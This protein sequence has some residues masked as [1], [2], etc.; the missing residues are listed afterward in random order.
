VVTIIPGNQPATNNTAARADPTHASP[1][2]SGPADLGK[3]VQVG[4]GVEIGKPVTVGSPVTIATPVP[5]GTAT[6]SGQETSQIQTVAIP[7]AST[8]KASSW[9]SP[10][11]S[12][13]LTSSAA[14]SHA[15]SFTKAPN[16]AV[17]VSNQGKTVALTSPELATLQYGY[18][19]ASQIANTVVSDIKSVSD[20]NLQLLQSP[21]G[22]TLTDALA[23]YGGS[24]VSKGVGAAA[25]IPD[26][27]SSGIDIWKGRYL[28]AANTLTPDAL[29]YGATAVGGVWGGVVFQASFDVGKYYVAP[30]VAPWIGSQMY[31][32]DPSLFTPT[33]SKR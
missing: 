6:A 22:S 10:W 30:Y 12:V 20:K 25:Y 19:P 26:A 9:G 5:I 28:G 14:D 13:S 32:L 18:K 23:T 17:Q 33:S 7:L 31:D 2:Q 3:P 11:T 1:I 8:S 21:F 29:G 4:S 16:G 27:I 15:Y 24:Q